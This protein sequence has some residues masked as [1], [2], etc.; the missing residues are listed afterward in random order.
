M[1]I[2]LLKDVRK[3][4]KR[5]EIKDVAD[6]FALNALIPAGQAVPATTSNLKMVENKKAVSLTEKKGFVEAL[7]KAFNKLQDGKL[8]IM[9]KTNEKGHLFAGVH[10]EQ[11]SEA[12]KIQTGLELSVES[13]ELEKPIKEIGE[14][15]IKIS[16]FDFSRLLT[17]DIK[18][19]E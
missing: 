17:V 19:I 1:K 14:N 4:G 12:F 6:G 2:I 7:D 10:K 8:V 15:K 3:V 13:I 5:Y 11:I 9:G 18:A 16:V